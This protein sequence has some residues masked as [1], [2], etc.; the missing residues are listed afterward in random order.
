[1][2]LYSLIPLFLFPFQLL[3]SFV[4]FYCPLFLFPIDCKFLILCVF[5]FGLF[6]PTYFF[7]F[8]HTIPIFSTLPFHFCA[9]LD[10]FP[11]FESFFET[12]SRLP[13]I[14]YPIYILLLNFLWWHKFYS[15]YF[16]LHLLDFMF[17]PSFHGIV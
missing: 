8:S 1:M 16:F 7:Y 17:V 14:H 3:H 6:P 9:F 5:F 4:Q 10:M 12:Y 11:I 15:L 13:N 2:I